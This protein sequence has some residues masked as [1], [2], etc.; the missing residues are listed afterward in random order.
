MKMRWGT[1][2][3]AAAA[4]AIVAGCVALAEAVDDRIIGNWRRSSVN[5]SAPLLAN[6][7]GVSADGEYSRATAGI[8][9]DKGSWS[10]NGDGYNFDGLFF[11]F[12]GTFTNIVP[13]F[14]DSDRTFSYTD[15]DGYVEVYKK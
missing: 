10:K 13:T 11:G 9:T 8:V 12:I 14:S 5:G 15:G 3:A 1:F 2:L 6:E 4:V 7:L